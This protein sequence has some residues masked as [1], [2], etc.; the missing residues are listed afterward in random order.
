MLE[1]NT[2]LE[3]EVKDLKKQLEPDDEVEQLSVL[4]AGKNKSYARTVA[5]AVQRP[6][7]KKICEICHLICETEIQ[8]KYHTQSH[9]AEGDW[10]C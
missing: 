4:M 3:T 10:K 7:K 9:D 8:Y 5:G 1:K 6:T 2:K